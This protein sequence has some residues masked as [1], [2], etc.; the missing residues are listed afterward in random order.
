[1]RQRLGAGARRLI[2]SEHDVH[3]QTYAYIELYA[4]LSG[5]TIAPRRRDAA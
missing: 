3:R 4:E 2:E 5:R 1:L